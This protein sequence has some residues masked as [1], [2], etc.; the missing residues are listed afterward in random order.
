MDRF[1]IE[2][3]H[4]PVP[5]RIGGGGSIGILL[6]TG[7][8]TGQD[9]PASIGLSR[10]LV[11]RGYR[12]MTFEYAYRAAGRSF[13]DREPKL[14]DV[15]RSA[16]EHLRPQVDK[17]VLAGRSMGGRMATILASQ[18]EACDAVVAHAYP[19]H[20]AGQPHKLR[21]EHLLDLRVP[22]LMVIGSN[23][24]LATPELV[25]AHLQPLAAVT[26]QVIGGAD[27]SFRGNG[28]GLD[29]I[30]DDLADRT[31]DWLIAQLADG[32]DDRP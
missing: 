15:H 27:H 1:T 5:A 3:P 32:P 24:A 31:H 23:D 26:L 10:R 29:E 11:D 14:L 18:G 22:T 16:A 20:P 4:G 17:L 13:P 7:A 2:T 8:G 30:L 28:L 12:T 21:I 6:A 19:L 9:H 25:E